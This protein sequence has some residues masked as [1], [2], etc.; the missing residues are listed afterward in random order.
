MNLDVVTPAS[1][2]AEMIRA[3]DL[4]PVQTFGAEN[5][6]CPKCGHEWEDGYGLM[7]RFSEHTPAG[8]DCNRAVEFIMRPTDDLMKSAEVTAAIAETWKDP[9]DELDDP[10]DRAIEATS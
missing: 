7:D 4:L 5:A 3:G 1:R 2:L 10:V 9:W 8:S 6:E